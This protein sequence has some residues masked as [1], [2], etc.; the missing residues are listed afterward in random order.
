MKSRSFFSTYTFFESQNFFGT[1]WAGR[2]RK[3]DILGHQFETAWRER[4]LDEF[5]GSFLNRGIGNVLQNDPS[6]PVPA[7]FSFW[8]SFRKTSFSKNVSK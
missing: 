8:L 2:R 3:I 1:T 5:I 4:R 6:S 7:F